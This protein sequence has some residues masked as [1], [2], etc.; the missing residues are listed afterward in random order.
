MKPCRILIVE[1]ESLVA[2]DMERMLK[3]LG[4]EVLPNANNYHEALQHLQ[5]HLPDLVLLDITLNDSKTGIELSELIQQQYK[6]PFIYI[7]S[8]SDTNTINEALATE[9]YGY[10]LKPFD[11]PELYTTIEI[12]LNRF[13]AEAD[14]ESPE[15]VHACEDTLFIKNDKNFVRVSIDDILWIQSEHNYLY[16]ITTKQKHIIRS[17]FKDLQL[18]LPHNQFMQVHKSYMVNLKK[19]DAFSYTDITINNQEI[20]LSRMFKDDLFSR[21]KRIV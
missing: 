18:Q 11:A 12:A 10:L 2:M 21:M 13:V 3:E 9:P 16:L 19:I 20:P 7:T 15:Q 5:N 14:Q 17:N 6:I 1:D 4:Y 8:H